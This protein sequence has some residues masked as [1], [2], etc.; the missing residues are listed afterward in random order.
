MWRNIKP[1]LLLV[2]FALLLVTACHS[3]Q[4]E[5][6]YKV[7]ESELTNIKKDLQ[8]IKQ[9]KQSLITDLNNSKLSLQQAETQRMAIEK[10]SADLEQKLINY[11]NRLVKQE[12]ELTALSD[13]RKE[14]QAQL[15]ELNEFFQQYR[16]EVKS[17]IRKLVIQRNI[18]TFIATILGVLAL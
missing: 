12:A 2:L 6:S 5:G 17:K 11:Q 4:A 15:T 16:K 7:Y 10:R 18:I 1:T 8:L 14:L 13:M 9:E 3:C